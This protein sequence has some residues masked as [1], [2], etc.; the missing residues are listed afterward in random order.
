MKLLLWSS[1]SGIA[2]FITVIVILK[3]ASG[4]TNTLEKSRRNISCKTN[5]DVS[6]DIPD[7]EVK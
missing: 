4:D 7:Y 2:F 3:Y 5:N 6:V 1:V